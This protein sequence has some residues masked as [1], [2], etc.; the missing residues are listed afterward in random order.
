MFAN[1]VKKYALIFTGSTS[2]AL[3]IVGIFVPVL[4]TTP[5]LLLTSFCYIRSS[6]RLYAWLI[7]HRVFGSFIDNYMNYRAVK[8]S[9]KIV[10][11][12]F[13]WIMLGRSI[14]YLSNLP[15]RMLLFAI[16]IGV[17]IHILTLKTLTKDGIKSKGQY[18]ISN[19]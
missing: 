15:L 6:K 17:S 18:L 8:R 10:T 3:G 4:P 12:I 5:F 9:T 2:L 11:L 16:G 1:S 14:Y 7:N 19:I 13:L